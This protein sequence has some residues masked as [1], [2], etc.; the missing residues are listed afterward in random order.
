MQPAHYTEVLGLLAEVAVAITTADVGGVLTMRGWPIQI[1]P[2]AGGIS[3]V[4]LARQVCD[5]ARRHVARVD[6]E[7]S[8]ESD[9]GELNGEAEPR[10]VFAQLINDAAITVVEVKVLAQLR[11]RGFAGIT[12]ITALLIGGQEIDGHGVPQ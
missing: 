10:V 5:C 12:A 2:L 6:Q 8:R 4:E 7:G 1:A 9:R 11:V 3:N